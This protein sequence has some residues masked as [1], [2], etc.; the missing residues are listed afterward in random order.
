MLFGF[1]SP[2][3]ALKDRASDWEQN[4]DLKFFSTWDA[5]FEAFLLKY[6]PLNKT[7]KL[8]ANITS[9]AQLHGE[10]LYEA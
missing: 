10:S 3:H 6:F 4:K 8:S 2:S 7:G 1:S 5:L 9:F